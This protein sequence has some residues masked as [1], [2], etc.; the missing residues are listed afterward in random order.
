MYRIL[1]L[2]IGLLF[3][4]ISL[5]ACNKDDDNSKE[6]LL[7]GR[8]EYTGRGSEA[9]QD[10]QWAICTHA[11]TKCVDSAK[12]RASCEEQFGGITCLSDD[13]A[14]DCAADLLSAEKCDMSLYQACGPDVIADRQTAIDGCNA[15][16]VAQCERWLTCLDDDTMEECI[17]DISSMYNCNSAI[18]LTSTYEDCID[19]VGN[20][21]CTEPEPTVCNSVV[22]VM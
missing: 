15:L 17:E 14:S 4:C 11:Y 21:G 6:S 7:S 8:E 2:A 10:W 3:L 1:K 19:A 9:C 5:L 16:I 12:E 22:L 18:G 13:A 20:W